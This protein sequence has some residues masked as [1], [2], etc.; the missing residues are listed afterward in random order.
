[1]DHGNNSIGGRGTYEKG[2]ITTL[3]YRLA[4]GEVE[5]TLKLK[6]GV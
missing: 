2:Y 6:Y 3:N 1:V 5:M 4:K